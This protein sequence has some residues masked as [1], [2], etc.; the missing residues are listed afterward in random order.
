MPFFPDDAPV[1]EVLRTARFV[2]RPL[3]VV[4]ALIDQEAYVASPGTIRVHS[5]GQWP[6]ENFTVADDIPLLEQH[7]ARHQARQ[8][9]AFLMLDPSET[10]GLGCFYLLPLAPFLQHYSVPDAVRALA[11]EDAVMATFWVRQSEQASGLDREVVVAV[12][13]WLTTD[14]PFSQ[15]YWRANQYEQQ[16]LAAL[17]GA[18]L[19]PKFVVDLPHPPDRYIFF[20]TGAVALAVFPSVTN[21]K[22]S[23]Q[24]RPC[25]FP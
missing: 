3:R 21:R 6:T 12:Q 17:A 9:F 20:G 10:I 5:G 19:H 24:A 16:S 13:G 25:P 8:D 11:N 1:P 2:A 18:G 22:G 15:V 4:D 7:E 23:E 14:W